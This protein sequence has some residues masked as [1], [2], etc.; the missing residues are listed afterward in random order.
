MV[1]NISAKVI[2]NVKFL[3]AHNLFKDTAS[4]DSNDRGVFYSVPA[5]IISVRLGFGFAKSSPPEVC[6]GFYGINILATDLRLR[7]SVTVSTR[8]SPKS[9][10]IVHTH[11]QEE[12]VHYFL[13]HI[14]VQISNPQRSSRFVV[15]V[16]HD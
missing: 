8:K 10:N 3:Y 15:A 7:H 6:T 12:L 9:S 1:L 11:L 14:F 2:Q 16:S 13:R 4:I 5:L